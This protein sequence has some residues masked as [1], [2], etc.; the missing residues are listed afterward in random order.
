MR[1]LLQ[2]IW[3]NKKQIMEGLLNNIV[4]QDSVEIIAKARW[5]ICQDCESVDI[6]G[7]E[8]AIPGTQ[9]CCKECGC[10][11]SLKLRSLSSD[12]PKGY[13]SSVLTIEEENKLM[14][15]SSK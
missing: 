2:T 14:N 15:L 12:C 10:S 1:N 3:E 7:S 8:C 6:D 5:G 13:W 11:L 4:K 9:P